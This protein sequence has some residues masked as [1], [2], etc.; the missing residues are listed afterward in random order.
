MFKPVILFKVCQIRFKRDLVREP[1]L[2][3][4]IYILRDFQFSMLVFLT[5]G[6]VLSWQ[7]DCTRLYLFGCGRTNLLDLISI[8][9][10]QVPTNATGQRDYKLVPVWILAC[11]IQ[12]IELE[13]PLSDIYFNH[14]NYKFELRKSFFFF[15]ID[16]IQGKF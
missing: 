10:N 7:F 16:V 9:G 3:R 6:H 11:Q 2:D 5:L 12:L 1:D 13:L 8:W 4:R 15:S 14:S